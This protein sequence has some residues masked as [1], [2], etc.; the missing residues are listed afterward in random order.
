MNKTWLSTYIIKFEEPQ[1]FK[2]L[3]Y[4][5]RSCNRDEYEC[6]KIYYRHSDKTVLNYKKVIIGKGV[7]NKEHQRLELTYS[8]L[9]NDN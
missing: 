7:Y 2:D 6:E 3:M 1:K 4:I 5:N 8:E 9:L